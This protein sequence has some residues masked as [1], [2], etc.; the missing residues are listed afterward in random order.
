MDI[1]FLLVQS[2][3]IPP[4]NLFHLLIR[5]PMSPAKMLHKS[6][7]IGPCKLQGITGYS[8][9]QSGIPS[10]ACWLLLLLQCITYSGWV[11][12]AP[13]DNSC[14]LGIYSISLERCIQGFERRVY[15]PFLVTHP[16]FWAMGAQAWAKWY[17]L[18]EP[19]RPITGLKMCHTPTH[20][21]TGLL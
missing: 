8:L 14:Q 17:N 18:H 12:N 15:F 4:C 7:L 11:W 16:V 19:R 20:T 5:E 21:H 3:V 6:D 10:N 2:L 9:P 13:S 1:V